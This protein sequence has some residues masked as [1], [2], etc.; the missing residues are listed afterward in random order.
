[1]KIVDGRRFGKV[2]IITEIEKKVHYE[3][4]DDILI[5]SDMR[6]PVG[7]APVAPTRNSQ[8]FSFGK[9]IVY[10]NSSFIVAP[11]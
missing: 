7:L 10:F 5:F 1:M 4:I 11:I 8:T 2:Q 6:L 3:I 9:V